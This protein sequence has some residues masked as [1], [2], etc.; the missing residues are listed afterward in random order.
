MAQVAHDQWLPVTNKSTVSF[1]QP[2]VD[3]NAN[4]V[5]SG[6]IPRLFQGFTGPDNFPFAVLSRLRKKG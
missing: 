5:R 2:T 3:Y 4:H 1:T 6:E